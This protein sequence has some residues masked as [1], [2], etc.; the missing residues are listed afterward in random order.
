MSPDC[1]VAISVKCERESRTSEEKYHHPWK[2]RELILSPSH[3]LAVNE[4][5]F[6]NIANNLRYFS[7]VPATY[8]RPNR[9]ISPAVCMYRVQ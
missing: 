5:L 7:D 6:K 2:A 3:S 4:F 1:Y 9:P 8:T